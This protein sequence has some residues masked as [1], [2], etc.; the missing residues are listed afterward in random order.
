MKNPTN[1]HRSYCRS[2]TA[3]FGVRRRCR[4][5]Q[6]L[7]Q[8]FGGP[9]RRRFEKQIQNRRRVGGRRQSLQNDM[10]KPMQ[11]DTAK[12]KAAAAEILK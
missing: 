9:W 10:M 3:S 7:P 5:L 1:L 4:Y 8:R 11:A 2:V 6:R 12:L